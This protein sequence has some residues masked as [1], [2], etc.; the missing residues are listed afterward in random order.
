LRGPEFGE[1]DHVMMVTMTQDGPSISN[2]LLDGILSAD[3]KP[4][5]H[6]IGE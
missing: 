5:V 2:V 3:G 6:D 1:F 4:T